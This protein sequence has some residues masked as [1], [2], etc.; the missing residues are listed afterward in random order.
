VK[1]IEIKELSKTVVA[2]KS[3]AETALA[4]VLP[5]LKEACLALSKLD[6]NDITEI[7]CS[8]TAIVIQP[9]H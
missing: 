1:S 7:R 9:F 5:A 2:E 4:E 8:F 3:E 6:K